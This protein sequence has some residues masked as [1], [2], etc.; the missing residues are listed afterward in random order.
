MELKKM[1]SAAESEVNKL[2]SA[3][4]IMRDCINEI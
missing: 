3:I 4:E 2:K 1:K